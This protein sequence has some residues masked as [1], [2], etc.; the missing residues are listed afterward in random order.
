[1][2]DPATFSCCVCVQVL[3]DSGKEGDGHGIPS[4]IYISREKSP[5]H[6][7][8]FKAGAMNVLVRPSMPGPVSCGKKMT[9]I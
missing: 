8:H 4:L 1:M 2:P 5:R 7:H 9:A 3:W 6:P